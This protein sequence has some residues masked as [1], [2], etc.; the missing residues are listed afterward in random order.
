[1]LNNYSS[2]LRAVIITLVASL[3]YVD[4]ARASE[5]ESTS[6]IQ[7]DEKSASSDALQGD[8][9]TWAELRQALS[10]G[11]KAKARQLIDEIELDSL[12]LREREAVEMLKLLLVSPKPPA[13]KVELAAPEVKP[14]K[15]LPL[16]GAFSAET[17]ERIERNT[18]ESLDHMSTLFTQG[19]IAGASLLNTD[20]FNDADESAFLVPAMTG[21]SY[22]L[23]AAYTLG[24]EELTRGDIPLIDGLSVYLPTHTLL[25]TNGL[26][27]DNLDS[28]IY[29]WLYFGT[30]VASLPLAYAISGHFDPDPGDTQLIRDSVFWGGLFGWGSYFLFHPDDSQSSGVAFRS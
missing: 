28:D 2:P 14:S 30:S 10:K 11:D 9:D 22:A 7:Q 19:I 29:P 24:D 3:S 12:T 5:T 1:M 16:Y 17:N 26:F 27:W 20:Y 6:T 13:P 21:L 23:F 15:I 25:L 4:L 18:F 8:R